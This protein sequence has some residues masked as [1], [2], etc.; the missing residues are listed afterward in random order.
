MY[1]RNHITN[2]FTLI[3]LMLSVT[4]GMLIV[5]VATSGLRVA[6]QTVSTANRLATENAVLR[7][8]FQIA[9]AETDFWLSYDDPY[10]TSDDRFKQPLRVIGNDKRQPAR[11]HGLPFTPLKELHD[12]NIYVKRS[13]INDNADGWEQDRSDENNGSRKDWQAHLPR[14]WAWGNLVEKVS[15]QMRLPIWS[16]APPGQ[17][18]KSYPSENTKKRQLFGKYHDIASSDL[19]SPRGWQQRQLDGLNRSMGFIGV[20]DYLPANAPLMIYE[21]DGLLGDAWTVSREWCYVNSPD[22]NDTRPLV[23]R[24]TI[25]EFH[26]GNWGGVSSG[27]H[28]ATDMLNRTM[29]NVFIFPRGYSD[30]SLG[31]EPLTRQTLTQIGSKRY[32]TGSWNAASNNKSEDSIAHINIEGETRVPYLNYRPETWPDLEVSSVRHVR[33]GS[34]ICMNRISWT[35]PLTGALLT[36][37]FNSIGTTFRGAR[38]QRSRNPNKGFIDPFKPF[39]SNPNLDTY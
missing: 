26:L 5:Y 34:Q 2:A 14:T 10:D 1:I 29:E 24:K 28:F 19:G 22:P 18:N 38:Q 17:G 6:S 33:N 36:M 35:N 39:S 32:S 7:A 30:P 23:R 31:L 21:K 3:E 9:L 27:F 12:L 37:S 16:P 15:V 8:G 11:P 25:G 4:L 13:N 20:F